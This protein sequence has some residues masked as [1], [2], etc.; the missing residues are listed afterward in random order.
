MFSRDFQNVC[1]TFH[2]LM[3]ATF[4]K[5]FIDYLVETYSNVNPE[6]SYEPITVNSWNDHSREEIEVYL[7]VLSTSSA[8]VMF[9]NL[10]VSETGYTLSY[11][12]NRGCSFS[13]GVTT[14][15]LSEGLDPIRVNFLKR[16]NEELET[17]VSTT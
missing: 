10:L 9:N 15:E 16:V 4:P 6:T 1:V 5:W 12:L 8:G 11:S 3:G 14:I 2:H 17:L 7:S 13:K